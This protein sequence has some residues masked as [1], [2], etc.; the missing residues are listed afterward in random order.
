M[1]AG[2]GRQVGGRQ[3]GRQAGGRRAAV[4]KLVG[5]QAGRQLPE[6][7]AGRR[8]N[9]PSAAPGSQPRRAP[10]CHAAGDVRVNWRSGPKASAEV[11]A[12]D[13]I[14]VSGKGRVQVSLRCTFVPELLLQLGSCCNQFLL[15][16]IPA[17]ASS[18]HSAQP[19]GGHARSQ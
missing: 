2:I 6:W 15:Q 3:A 19:A 5:Q 7:L 18:A 12:G 16:S 8:H 13:L 4:C 9:T 17:A 14:S 11:K 1:L 10:P